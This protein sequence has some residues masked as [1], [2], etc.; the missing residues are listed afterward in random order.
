[1]SVRTNP[2]PCCTITKKKETRAIA[3]RRGPNPSFLRV[4]AWERVQ[5]LARH[6]IHAARGVRP[7]A[8]WPES[9]RWPEREWPFL[10]VC[11]RSSLGVCVRSTGPHMYALFAALVTVDRWHLSAVLNFSATLWHRAPYVLCVSDICSICFIWTLH[12]FYLDVAYGSFG[13]CICCNGYTY[14][15]QV[16]VSAISDVLPPSTKESNSHISRS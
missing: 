4:S 3:V 13:C 9:A 11:V 6:R 8:V 1:M 5:S 14:M 12:V 15:L 16:Y 2:D 7:C 10:G